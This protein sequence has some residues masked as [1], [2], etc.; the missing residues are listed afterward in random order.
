MSENYRIIQDNLRSI[1]KLINKIKQLDTRILKLETI[2]VKVCN[3]DGGLEE[4]IDWAEIAQERRDSE[5]GWR[6]R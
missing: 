5:E 2:I 6:D 3:E 1:V 4:D